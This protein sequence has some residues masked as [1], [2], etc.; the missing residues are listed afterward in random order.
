MGALNTVAGLPC[1]E[2][3]PS[4]DRYSREW[5]SSFRPREF[6]VLET[7]GQLCTGITRIQLLRTQTLSAGASE[8]ARDINWRCLIYKLTTA[9][10]IAAMSFRTIISIADFFSRSNCYVFLESDT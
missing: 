5:V 10:G 4:Q 9:E 3:S 7:V 6:Q 1:S 8:T 2:Q